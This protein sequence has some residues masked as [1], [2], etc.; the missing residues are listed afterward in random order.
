MFTLRVV[1]KTM[2]ACVPAVQCPALGYCGGQE[3]DLEGSDEAG[4]NLSVPHEPRAGRDPL[5]G[6]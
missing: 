5:S 2:S 3:G 6:P 4:N 1:E